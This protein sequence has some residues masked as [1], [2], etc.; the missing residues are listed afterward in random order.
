MRL[1]YPL[2]PRSP[3]FDVRGRILSG[4]DAIKIEEGT[5]EGI[6]ALLGDM[7]VETL[8]A[9]YR[10]GI[11]PWPHANYPL[12]WFSPDPRAILELSDVHVPK[13]L[14]KEQRKN[15]FTFTIDRAFSQVITY[16]QVTKRPEQDDTWITPALRRAFHALHEAGTAHSVEAWDENGELA[17]GLYG[18]NSG[19][20]F[21]GE[22]MFY[23]QPY[24][25]KLCLLYLFDH[26]RTRGS[27]FIDIQVM[28]PHFEQLG[29]KNI[30]RAEFLRKLVETQAQNLAIFS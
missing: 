13:S 14:A 30:P 9:A 20:V 1:S 18:V 22:S 5:P 23:H 2:P 8:Q 15:R 26:L 16:C 19:G 17:G 27:T 24:A 28:T 4:V 10:R 12:C 7:S 3:F 6:V 25:S 21:T 29:A 11:F